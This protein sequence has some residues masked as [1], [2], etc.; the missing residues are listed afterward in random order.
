MVGIILNLSFSVHKNTR[1]QQIAEWLQ[2]QLQV[3]D[4]LGMVRA[5]RGSEARTVEWFFFSIYLCIL[6]MKFYHMYFEIPKAWFFHDTISWKLSFTI[7]RFI[8][9]NH[10]IG[11]L[12]FEKK[13]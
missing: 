10:L 12:T 6:I 13:Y 1:E 7:S 5:R 4:V 2:L 11:Y 9:Y 3:I 8:T